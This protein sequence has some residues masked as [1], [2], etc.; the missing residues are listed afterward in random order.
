MRAATRP[1]H[2][3]GVMT[4]KPDPILFERLEQSL[5]HRHRNPLWVVRRL[6]QERRHGRQ[7]NGPGNTRRAIPCQVAGHLA[8]GRR[9]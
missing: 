8:A 1:E 7:Q 9:R 4:Q 3:L 5:E 2:R 6:S